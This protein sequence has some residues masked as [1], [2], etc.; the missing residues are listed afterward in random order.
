M[1]AHKAPQARRGESARR[2]ASGYG[3]LLTSDEVSSSMRC[4]TERL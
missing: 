2:F 3:H 4:S 1:A